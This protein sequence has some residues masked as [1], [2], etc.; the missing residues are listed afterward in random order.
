MALEA[1]ANGLEPPP[2][3]HPDVSGVVVDIPGSG[4]FAALVALTD[5][6]TS[7]YT[8]AGGG[9]IGAGQHADVAA[10]TRRLLSVVQEHLGGFPDPDDKG[11]PPPG[12]V[13]FH[14][15]TPSG[16][17]HRDVP[18][19]AFWGEVEHALAPVIGAA[20]DVL[21]AVRQAASG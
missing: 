17:R 7:M 2:A 1:V 14:V 21:T 10:A 20:Q 15:L 8:S 4:G 13:R 12:E 19:D 18:E 9:V 6:T 5:G 3:D 11:L 16:D